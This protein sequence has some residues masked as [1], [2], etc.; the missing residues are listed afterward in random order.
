MSYL[1]HRSVW[2]C[3]SKALRGIKCYIDIIETYI[4]T[5]ENFT[6]KSLDYCES[7]HG[8]KCFLSPTYLSSNEINLPAIVLGLL[9]PTFLGK[10]ELFF[11][12]P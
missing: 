12:L 9:T 10:H 1:A 4:L 6:D 2:R 3:N 8:E 5:T 11:E 7:K